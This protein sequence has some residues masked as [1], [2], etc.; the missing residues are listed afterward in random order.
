MSSVWSGAPRKTLIPEIMEKAFDSI[1]RDTLWNILLAYGCQEKIVSV[2]KLFYD[3]FCC[4]VIPGQEQGAS[5]LWSVT[6]V[7]P[8]SHCLDNAQDDRK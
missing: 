2:I 1:N 7:I 8:S 4:S 3:N 5:R 6:H